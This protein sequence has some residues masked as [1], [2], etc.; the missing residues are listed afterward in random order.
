MTD[1]RD[2]GEPPRRFG[3]PSVDLLAR[4]WNDPIDYDARP[5][6]PAKRTWWT[7][8]MVLATVFV[9]GVVLAVAYRQTV[10]AEPANASARSQLRDDV[11]AQRE[12][13]A[14]LESSADTLRDDVNRLRDQLIGGEETVKQ[15]HDAEALA[16]VRAV[17]GDGFTVT[18]TNGPGPTDP[19]A[20]NPGK[21]YD[22]D[23]QLVVNAIWAY[24]AE[25]VAIDDQRLTATSSIR[26]AGDAILVDFAP[27]TSP[28]R[29]TVI[30]PR[31]LGDRLRDSPTAETF[32]DYS[33][34]YGITMTIADSR[35]LRLPA[36]ATPPMDNAEPKET[37]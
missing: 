4:F 35:D 17:T 27:V 8:A 29:I 10:A 26:A 25:A 1:S 23:L 13:N 37:N 18:V 2:P 14:D 22:R 3:V 9:V 6:G 31:N 11:T 24:G 21:V 33:S 5:P 34:K 20:P 19:S 30:G 15:L 28:Y 36:A 32:S 16:G 12:A 7:R